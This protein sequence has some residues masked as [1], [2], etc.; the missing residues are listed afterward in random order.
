MSRETEMFKQLSKRA[1]LEKS[2]HICNIL[3][4][5]TE[6]RQLLNQDLITSAEYNKIAVSSGYRS[7]TQASAK[8]FADNILYYRFRLTDLYYRILTVYRQYKTGFVYRDNFPNLQ[9]E[10][11]E[12]LKYINYYKLYQEI[13]DKG[14][15]YQSKRETT[16]TVC[17]NA[18]KLSHIVL[19][20]P[21]IDRLKPLEATMAH[22]MGHAAYNYVTASTIQTPYA[23]GIESEIM[24]F[25]FERMF[26]DFLRQ[27]G[28]IEPEM[29][30]III[31]NYETNKIAT[32]KEARKV[33]DIFD[34]PEITYE[35]NR[36]EITYSNR[37]GVYV[38]DFLDQPYAV[39]NLAA[40][41][42]YN[43]YKEDPD[44]FVKHLP[45]LM[46]D[47][48]NKDFLGIIDEYSDVFALKKCLD[49][50]LTRK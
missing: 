26:L 29:M 39:G 25:T 13:K 34:D 14:Y 37:H 3:K 24:S 15:I 38:D 9:K 6:A 28:V 22:E 17:H 7:L 35:V 31:K 32:T 4:I 33:L 5:V 10:L 11:E 23:I 18:G 36:V 46:K 45:G 47:I 43:D 30:N 1:E 41:M 21:L 12:F 16:R 42:L 40:A 50:N 2:R 48:H 8:A 27:R 49:G 44:Y 20:N 19:K